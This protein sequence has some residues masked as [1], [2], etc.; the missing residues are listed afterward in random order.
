MQSPA[1]FLH[2]AQRM[3]LPACRC[4]RVV[5]VGPFLS[6]F[7]SDRSHMMTG[8]SGGWMQ[9]PPPWPRITAPDGTTNSLPAY[10]AFPDLHP[11]GDTAAAGAPGKEPHWPRQQ[12]GGGSA[13][14]AHTSG[15]GG[16]GGGGGLYGE[17]LT[18]A[19]F[20]RRFGVVA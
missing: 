10:L 20:L 17:V 4:Y 13:A 11:N 15:D 9:P 19:A 5:P 2:A 14:A 7:A 8:Q 18:E 3:A 12:H 1:A 6:H 16:D